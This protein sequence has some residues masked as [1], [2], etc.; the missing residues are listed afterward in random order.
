MLSND[1]E[2]ESLMKLIYVILIVS[3]VVVLLFVV[4]EG[5]RLGVRR[6]WAPFVAMFTVGVSLALPLFL[7]LRQLRIG[8][9]ASDELNGNPSKAR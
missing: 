8:E 1:S 3:A 2:R 5:R 7:L 6:L 4:V 9:R